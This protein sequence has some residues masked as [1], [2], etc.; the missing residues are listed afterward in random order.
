[1][2][3]IFYFYYLLPILWE[4]NEGLL[5]EGNDNL[6]LFAKSSLFIDI[7]SAIMKQYQLTNILS[8][9]M[10]VFGIKCI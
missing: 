2:V 8:T 3:I 4:N 7:D 10:N 5:F 1:M 6:E 9:V